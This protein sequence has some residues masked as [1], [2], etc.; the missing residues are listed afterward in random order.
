M[1]R[2]AQ[3]LATVKM[4]AICCLLDTLDGEYTV[5]VTDHDLGPKELHGVGMTA[6]ITLLLHIVRQT[7]GLYKVVEK[8][9][10]VVSYRD[11]LLGWWRVLSAAQ[12]TQI[13]TKVL[14]PAVKGA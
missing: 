7:S 2:S 6:A 12:T 4:V 11:E 9:F 13:S 5:D 1:A 8:V 3:S 14:V 10:F